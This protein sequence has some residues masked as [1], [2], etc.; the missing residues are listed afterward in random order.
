M[1]LIAGED[2]WLPSPSVTGPMA[3]NVPDL[4]LLLSVLAGYD[5]RAPLSVD[6]PGT[7]FLIDFGADLKADFKGKRIGWT[8]DLG[9]AAPYES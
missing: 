3:R 2:V 8:A 9:G 1:I 6:G 7:R 5:S 4:A